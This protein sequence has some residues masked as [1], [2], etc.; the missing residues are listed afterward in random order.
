VKDFSGALGVDA[1]ILTA[2]TSSNEPIE[3]AAEACRPKG[4]IVLIGTAGLNLPR[5]PFFKKE[6]EFTVSSSLGPGRGDPVY[7]EKGI[8]YPVGYARWTAQRNMRAVLETMA[9]GRL[10]V[11]KLTTH[12]FP[13]DRAAE[14]YDLITGGREPHLG[15]LIEYPQTVAKP[16][17]RI[18]LRAAAA[19]TG[20][21][22][23]SMIGAGNFA[24]LVMMPM[25]SKASGLSWR[26]LCTAKGVNAEHSGRKMGFAFAA[27]DTAEILDD[28]QTRIVFIAT[29]HDLHADLV[30][31]CLRAGKNVFVEK[32]LCIKPEELEAV[33]EC[34]H[35]LGD[36]CPLLMVGF[37]RRF[38]PATAR[39]QGFFGAT[40]PLSVSYRFAPGYVPP[41]S[42]TQDPE[43]GGG[44]IIGEA[45]HAI[46]T[47]IALTG[48]LSAR[49][50]AES[51]SKPNST[52]TT[53]DSVFI[54]LRHE[55]GSIS[56]ISY[57]A[58]GDKAFPAERIEVFGGGRTAVIASW[59][60]IQLWT[61]NGCRKVSGKKDKGHA[62]EFS[63]FL[64]TCRDG[65]SWPIPW[66]QLYNVT[67][68]SLAAVQ[69]LRE[70]FPVEA[71]G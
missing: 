34:V 1:A 28:S 50:F 48:S 41:D 67:W 71:E 7:E 17:R 49:V 68:A 16:E 62:A 60:E 64:S 15:I 54:T 26:G 52:E 45:C 69:S 61:R 2:A 14:A 32:P 23:A 51:V 20:D 6:L 39:V 5:A 44:R 66:E 9:A 21:L 36:R 4:R 22:G 30:V 35:E 43:V 42:W 27:T 70:G 19:E 33:S 37:N 56:N 12:R 29:R 10:P 63:A 13:I 47:C 3:F 46:D 8:D 65:G 55:N 59:D 38:A 18:A 31:A 11:E 57:Q 24:R 25:L 53:D 58:G 40:A